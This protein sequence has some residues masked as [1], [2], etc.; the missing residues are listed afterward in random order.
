MA[1]EPP[2]PEKSLLD[3][4][5]NEA[6]KKLVEEFKKNEARLSPLDRWL[7][8]NAGCAYWP[9]SIAVA[10]ALCLY[11]HF[12]VEMSWMEVSVMFIFLAPVFI[13][14]NAARIAGYRYPNKDD[15]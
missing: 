1:L 13:F 10:A 2:L 8:P 12:K 5:P 11:L 4:S 6:A 7:R 9:V 15:E 14:G 3:S